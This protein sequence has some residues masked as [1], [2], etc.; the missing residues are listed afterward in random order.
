MSKRSA[1]FRDQA[2]KCRDHANAVGA[3]DTQAQLLCLA[4]EYIMRA[5][6]IENEERG[7]GATF[8]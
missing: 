3:S 7:F 6:Q 2:N 4:A 8:H 5:V 1:Y